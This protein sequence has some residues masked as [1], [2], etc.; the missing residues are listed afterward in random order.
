MNLWILQI[1]V[2]SHR[3]TA[4][5]WMIWKKRD[6]DKYQKNAIILYDRYN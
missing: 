5:K 1:D 3:L 2:M 6:N 4:L